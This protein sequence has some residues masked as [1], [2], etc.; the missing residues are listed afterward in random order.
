MA[1]LCEIIGWTGAFLF[2]LAYFLLSVRKL[3][4]DGI[5]YQLLNV[6]AAICLIINALHL[7][8]Y[9][10]F[11]TNFVWMAIGIFSLY[12]ITKRIKAKR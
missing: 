5:Q 11:V 8:D 4:A 2:I 7:S 6:V 9:P 12:H 1:A 10:N 3:Q